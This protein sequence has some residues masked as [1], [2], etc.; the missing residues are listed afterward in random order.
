MQ[1]IVYES[2]TGN[3]KRY[4]EILGQKTGLPVY[5][6]KEASRHLNRQDE[7]IYLGWL[8]AS[9]IKGYKKAAEHYDVKAVCGVG[10][11]R[12]GEEALK[13]MIKQNH[14]SDP[15]AFYLQ[16]GYDV[17]KLS[18]IY[19]FMMKMMSKVILKEIEKKE[20]KTDEDLET[21]DMINNGRSLVK[22]ENLASILEWLKTIS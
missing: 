21:I 7:I 11:R 19:K 9:I 2:K 15:N 12:A 3:T 1:A 5:S 20:T 22:V 4:A 10:M 14:I 13:D 17:N 18:G 8:F 6:H 16:G